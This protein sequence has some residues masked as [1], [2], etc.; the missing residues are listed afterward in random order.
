[1]DLWEKINLHKTKIIAILLGIAIF[2]VMLSNQE[3]MDDPFIIYIEYDCRSVL[4]NPI[5]L[6]VEVLEKC[7]IILEEQNALKQSKRGA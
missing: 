1:M 2:Y 5:S 4:K 6:P 7:K 3:E